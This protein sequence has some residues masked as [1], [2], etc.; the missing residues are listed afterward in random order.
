MLRSGGSGL[1]QKHRSLDRTGTADGL[2][3]LSFRSS[4]T[5]LISKMNRWNPGILKPEW[6]WII[7]PSPPRTEGDFV[8][9]VTRMRETPWTGKTNGSSPGVGK[10]SGAEARA[11]QGSHKPGRAG[12]QRRGSRVEGLRPLCMSAGRRASCAPLRVQGSSPVR[13]AKE[14]R[15]SI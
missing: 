2:C 13:R 5:A 4:N 3:P 15:L 11:C 6:A 8:A 14:E 10:K 9:Q 7:S 1:V 12:W